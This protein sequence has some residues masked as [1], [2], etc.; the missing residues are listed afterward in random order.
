MIS[1]SQHFFTKNLKWIAIIC[2]VLF[3]FK[4]IQSC[5]RRIALDMG[6]SKYIEIIDSLKI[7]H[8]NYYLQS[9][10]SIKV[11]NFELKL[12]NERVQS[13]EQKIEAIQATINRL[14]QNTTITVRSAERDLLNN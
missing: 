2:F 1:T 11:L 6:S 12:A 9:Q 7:Q 10:D 13:A 3:L 4:T 8:N 5:N 14:R